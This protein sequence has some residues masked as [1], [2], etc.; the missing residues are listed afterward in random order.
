M[1]NVRDER[2]GWRDQWLSAR[3]KLWGFDCPATDLDF[4]MLEFNNEKPCALIDYKEEHHSKDMSDSASGRKASKILADN[5]KIPFLIVRYVSHGNSY[6]VITGNE[7]AYKACQE[8]MNVLDRTLTEVEY[9]TFLYWL[10]GME[11]PTSV[12]GE[13][14][15]TPVK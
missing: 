5:S 11:V 13:I 2:T 12:I 4:L 6:R 8:Y 7:Y 14:L 15:D 10:R 9:V 1:P 3:H